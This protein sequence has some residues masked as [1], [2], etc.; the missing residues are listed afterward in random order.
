MIAFWALLSLALA[1]Q[2]SVSHTTVLLAE[3]LVGGQSTD[4]DVNKRWTLQAKP[5][6]GPN[7]SGMFIVMGAGCGT[8]GYTTVYSAW[9]YLPHHPDN[10]MKAQIG[11]I[12]VNTKASFLKASAH[13]FASM[14]DDLHVAA[15][16]DW[17]A[18]PCGWRIGVVQA[19]SKKDGLEE[20]KTVLN[21]AEWFANNE[22][23]NFMWDV[24]TGKG[25]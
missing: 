22:Q 9:G 2:V 23:D 4:G 5:R 7:G 10:A 15:T 16:G 11:P 12:A 19:K 18:D 20:L 21:C 13:T 1:S 6:W 25:K 24:K 3:D 14:E 8:C 17:G